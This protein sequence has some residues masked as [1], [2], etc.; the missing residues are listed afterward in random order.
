M[1]GIGVDKVGVKMVQKASS[2]AHRFYTHHVAFALKF[3]MVAMVS[4][5]FSSRYVFNFLVEPSSLGLG[6]NRLDMCFILLAVQFIP[7]L[8]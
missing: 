1:G 6:D 4:G 7:P 2:F 5:T 8:E 3:L